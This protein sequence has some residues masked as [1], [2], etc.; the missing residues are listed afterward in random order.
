MT[1]SIS[2]HFQTFTFAQLLQK[3]IQ[4]LGIRLFADEEDDFE[5]GIDIYA[6][7]DDNI[8]AG[9]DFPSQDDDE[10]DEFADTELFERVLSEEEDPDDDGY[11]DD[12]TF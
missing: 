7:V 10:E 11:D 9:G 8:T 2:S 4:N 6:D 5:T 12:V 3:A 1:H